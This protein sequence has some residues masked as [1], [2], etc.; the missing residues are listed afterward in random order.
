[1]TKQKGHQPTPVFVDSSRQNYAS[2]VR[3]VDGFDGNVR[4]LSGA[5]IVGWV[6]RQMGVS[7]KVSIQVFVNGVLRDI[8]K[9]DGYS[10]DLT[11]VG[12]GDGRHSFRI[13]LRQYSHHFYQSANEVELRSVT[14]PVRLL[15]RVVLLPMSIDPDSMPQ[16][17]SEVRKV[18]IFTITFFDLLGE[19]Y[20]SGGAERYLV[21][22]V[23]LLRS[24]EYEVR[25]VQCSSVGN[26]RRFFHDIEVVGVPWDQSSLLAA[27]R[28]FGECHRAGAKAIFSPFVL[29]AAFCPTGSIGISHGIFWDLPGNSYHEGENEVLI[30][31]AIKHLSTLISVDAATLN[32]IRGVVPKVL[33]A[34]SSRVIINYVDPEQFCV[35]S[36]VVDVENPTIQAVRLLRDSGKRVLLYP[37]RLYA[38]RGLDI[39]LEAAS[40]LLPT[41]ADFVLLFVGRGNPADERKVRDLAELFPGQVFLTWLEA[42]YMHKAFA[43]ADVVLIPTLHSEGTSLSCV[44]ALF[45]GNCVITSHVGGLCEL[46]IDGFNGMVIEPTA[47][48]LL[49]AIIRMMDDDNLRAQFRLNARNTGRALVKQNWESKWADTVG[50]AWGKATF[51]QGPSILSAPI[52]EGMTI[53]HPFV[54]GIALNEMDQRPQSLLRVLG[55]GGVH[56]A[57]ADANGH[58][59]KLAEDDLDGA[60][61][62]IVREAEVFTEHAVIYFYYPYSLVNYS[63]S[64]AERISNSEDL[65]KFEFLCKKLKTHGG[66][67]PRIHAKKISFWFDYL[68]RMDIHPEADA[69]SLIELALKYSDVVTC[70]SRVLEDEA[71]ES[72]CKRIAYLGNAVSQEWGFAALQISPRPTHEVDLERV[73][74]IHGLEVLQQWRQAGLHIGVYWGAIASWTDLS[75]LDG[76]ESSARY[77]LIGPVSDATKKVQLQGSPIAI[78]IET[79][80]PTQ[81]SE[82]SRFCDFGIIPFLISGMTHCVNPLKL[83]EYLALGLPV[84]ATATQEM[85]IQYRS[86]PNQ[87]KTNVMLVETMSNL[88]VRLDPWLKSASKESGRYVR[89]F[90]SEIGELVRLLCELNGGRVGFELSVPDFRNAFVPAS[91]GNARVVKMGK[92]GR[93]PYSLLLEVP[94]GVDA[95]LNLEWSLS[96]PQSFSVDRIRMRIALDQD[97]SAA[98]GVL[99]EIFC[100]TKAGECPIARNRPNAHGLMVVDATCAIS[101][102]RF[103]CFRLRVEEKKRKEVKFARAIC[104]RV[105]DFGVPLSVNVS[106]NILQA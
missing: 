104:V 46:V 18:D 51:S 64:F 106:P 17:N 10:E 78:H 5:E 20:F 95:T 25:I 15:D 66:T 85:A 1:M 47:E 69:R 36:N 93:T 21:D 33:S 67:Q 48:E 55:S 91:I 103:L 23:Y 60:L 89:G 3:V 14:P 13:D 71:R 74:G 45:C 62:V 88:A 24:L 94:S 34:I 43:L 61:E 87:T 73:S 92:T 58:A 27:S 4:M 44:E 81:L 80:S 50:R 97:L 90:A 41:N 79:L 102:P 68:D 9:A 99:L 83:W 29:A 54:P 16:F 82:V 11:N 32:F 19:T 49:R 37:R 22:L 56:V 76:M 72:R 70:S 98:G 101:N 57:F 63:S 35:D 96:I 59:A 105:F 40:K 7:H 31:S 30:K 65:A 100:I 77:V 75:F 6:A 84:V 26:W 39:L 12:D 28:N 53:L 52:A 86:L 2:Q 38:P 42:E 8:V